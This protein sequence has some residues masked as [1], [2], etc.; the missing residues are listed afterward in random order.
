LSNCELPDAFD[1]GADTVTG[2][3]TV[4]G[5]VIGVAFDDDATSPKL[6]APSSATDKTRFLLVME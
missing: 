3:G 1:T 5:P 4:T 6:N 2:V